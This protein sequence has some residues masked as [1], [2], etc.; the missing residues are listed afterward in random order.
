MKNEKS[1]TISF[2]RDN[3]LIRINH[4]YQIRKR[5]MEKRFYSVYG[6]WDYQDIFIIFKV[7]FN[8]YCGYIQQLQRMKEKLYEKRPILVNP[9]NI[10]L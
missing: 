9:K 5:T 2:I 6:I 10:I 4:P 7:K 1:M 3:G 8:N